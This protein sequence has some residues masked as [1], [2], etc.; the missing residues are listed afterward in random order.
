MIAGAEAAGE[1][2]IVPLLTQNMKEDT[3][4]AEWLDVTRVSGQRELD[5]CCVTGAQHARCRYA[6][7]RSGDRSRTHVTE[8]VLDRSEC[9]RSNSTL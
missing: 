5:S 4:M 3:A 2:Q 6:A 7:G 1:G 8:S 9:F